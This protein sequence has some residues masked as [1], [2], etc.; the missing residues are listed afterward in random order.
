MSQDRTAQRREYRRCTIN[1]KCRC[2]LEMVVHPMKNNEAR[3]IRALNVPG[4]VGRSSRYRW[5][6]LEGCK[7]CALQARFR[8]GPKLHGQ[9]TVYMCLQNFLQ[10]GTTMQS[11]N[12]QE[13]VIV[14]P[15]NYN[16]YEQPKTCLSADSECI[17]IEVRTS[18]CARSGKMA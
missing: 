12:T 15:C 18:C 16:I 4:E 9:N 7:I 11:R 14:K 13:L 6:I 5:P 17:S 3:S 8:C 10:Q 2:V 1:R